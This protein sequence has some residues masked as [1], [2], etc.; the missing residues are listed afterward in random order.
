[1]SVSVKKMTPMLKQYLEIKERYPGCILFYRM[2]DFYEMFF[3][4]AVTAS[5]IL[6]ITLTSRDKKKENPVPMCG[7]PFHA[8]EGYIAK[9]VG[10]GKRVA[11]CEQVENPRKAKGIVKRKVTRVITPGLL[12]IDGGLSS[13]ENNFISAV[14]IN[15]A[16]KAVSVATLDITTGEFSVTKTNKEEAAL[17]ELFRIQPR[18]LLLSEKLKETGLFS[19][20]RQALP[21]VYVNWRPKDVFELKRAGQVLKEHFGVLTLEG[22]GLEA[23]DE[24]ISAAGALLLYCIDTH[25]G[26]I[27]HIRALSPYRLDS[28]LELDESTVRNLELVCSSLDG[29]VSGSLLHVIDKTSTPMGGRLLKRWLLYPLVDVSD[30]NDRLDA[31]ETLFSLV[32]ER[33]QIGTLLR[34]IYDMERLIGK[35]VMETAGP[36]DLLALR[37][38]ML[39]LPGIRDVLSAILSAK[40][41]KQN[42]QDLLSRLYSRVDPLEDVYHLIERAIRD[43]SPPM[44]REGNVIKEGFH[45]ELDELISIQKKG[46][47]F[48]AEIEAAEREKTGIQKLK[49]G[50]NRVF[51]YFIEVSK[52]QVSKVPDDYIRKQTL[53][54]AERY[55][56][57][58]L[59]EIEERIL[60][61]QERRIE[62]ELEVFKEVCTQIARHADRIQESASALAEIDCL[63]SLA[64]SAD[65][66][67]YN[68]PAMTSGDDI[69]I[70]QG[71]HPVVEQNLDGPVFVPND[72]RLDH[73]EG[74][75]NLITGPNMAGKSTVLR[76]TA[77]ICLMAQTGSFVPA[78]QARLPVLDRI[79][80]RVGATDYLSRGQ[81]TFM[82]EMKETANILNNATSKSLV[83]LDEIG[84]GTSTY[85]GLSIAWAVAEHL[86]FKDKKGVKTLFATHYHELTALEKRHRKV[87]N[88][89]VEVKEH[90]DR[91]YFLH[92]LREGATSKSYGIQVAALAG[93][94]AEVIEN[95]ARILNQIENENKGKGVPVA[96]VTS[97]GY[98]I[99]VQKPLPMQSDEDGEVKKRLMELEINRLTPIEALNILDKL[100]RYVKA[101]N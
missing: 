38:S 87:R 77:L 13:K 83:I 29:K 16:S 66:Y 67:G 94:P 2:G 14:S 30:I 3:E 72:I 15:R 100:C 41:A 8:A 88:L 81:S 86:L 74:L 62:L 46:R 61:A 21:E 26:S 57:S 36:R 90:D 52:S 70:V 56:T 27:N 98:K 31:V 4:D 51:G 84:R 42:C 63:C 55:I 92:T 7:I 44:L 64:E 43:E 23:G 50:Y 99:V 71:R 17:A 40:P 18:E 80:T 12:T 35:V 101:R 47:A 59:K 96:S 24:S 53:A 49:I 58:E 33:T 20:I 79:F 34:K 37:D 10:A 32:D 11:I 25:L 22:F 5:R 69:L 82:V 28:Y 6:Q 73:E 78:Q 65:L 9:L 68:R 91:I 1:M 48:I 76:Q 19:T 39:I 45:R 89:H 85:D 60:T 93:V 95:A 75:I 54:S 97:S